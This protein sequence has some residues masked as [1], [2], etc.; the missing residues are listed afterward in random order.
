MT[1]SLN[2][3][4]VGVEQISFI[5]HFD[6]FR[7]LADIAEV[8]GQAVLEVDEVLPLPG[9]EG[10]AVGLARADRVDQPADSHVQVMQ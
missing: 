2:N 9:V 8:M 3:S 10:N 1:L 5:P 7:R 6:S 4:V